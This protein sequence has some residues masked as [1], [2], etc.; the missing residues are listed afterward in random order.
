MFVW[1]G[2]N[3]YADAVDV[4]TIPNA[5][6]VGGLPFRA[7]TIDEIKRAYDD[8]DKSPGYA[9]VLASQ[10][11]LKPVLGTHDDH[12]FGINDGDKTF[13][14]REESRKLF[15]ER[16]IKA[17]KDDVR[18]T[19]PGVYFAQEFTLPKNQVM[20]V[21][22][23]DVRYNKDPWHVKDGEMLGEPQWK[24]LEAELC[25]EKQPI[26]RVNIIVSGL[27]VLMEQRGA[28]ESWSRF[29]RE[30]RR[31]LDL[32]GKCRARGVLLVSGDIHMAEINEAACGAGDL[33]VEATSSG[34]THSWGSRIN[35]FLGEYAV[36]NAFLSALMHFAQAVMPWR[37][38]VAHYLDLNAMQITVDMDAQKLA[39]DIIGADGK[40]AI[41][42]SYALEDLD[43]FSLGPCRPYRG[44]LPLHTARLWIARLL[45]IVIFIVAPVGL[46][47]GGPLLVVWLVV[48]RLVCGGGGTRSG[49]GTRKVV[50]AE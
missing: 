10:D 38:V 49:T 27:Q 46:L 13:P 43:R 11:L 18:W 22:M 24:W 6:R 19:R 41:S 36:V 5:L 37:Y 15:L 9:R 29:P 16:L 42:R 45:L 31:L 7:G 33:V 25:S 44:Y 28:G 50:K 30:R 17:P 21:V 35:T 20:R 3:V 8:L 4:S 48:R 2:D 47:L 23:L 32:L 26:P 12:D 40:P 1:G 34:L 14:L 39:V